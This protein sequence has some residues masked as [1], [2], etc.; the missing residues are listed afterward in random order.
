[1][2]EHIASRHVSPFLDSES[3]Q[4]HTTHIFDGASPYLT[5]DAVFAVKDSLVRQFHRHDPQEE[6]PPSGFQGPWYTV[7]C[8]IVLEPAVRPG[9]T[10]PSA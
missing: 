9:A 8:A 10:G 2:P 1:M 7:D 6:E 3:R 5:S 4:A